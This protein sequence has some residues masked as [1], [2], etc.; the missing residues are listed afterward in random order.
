MQRVAREQLGQRRGSVVVVDVDTGGIIA[1]WSYPSYNPNPLSS[2]DAEE[3]RAAFNF[4][5]PTSVTSPLPSSS[6]QNTFVPGS[7]SEV[8]PFR[9]L[10]FSKT[11]PPRPPVARGRGRRSLRLRRPDPPR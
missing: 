2:H 4:L 5:D 9:S 3:A 10:P 1:L 11:T 6:F 7:T 8:V